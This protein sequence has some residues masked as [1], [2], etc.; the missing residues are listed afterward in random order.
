[1]WRLANKNLSTPA[2]VLKGLLWHGKSRKKAE[3][4]FVTKKRLEAKR[5]KGFRDVSFSTIVSTV[6]FAS[7]AELFRLGNVVISRKLGWSMGG[8]MSEPATFR[9]KR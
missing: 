1:M 6:E 8:P 9:R 3:G 7:K 4:H 2:S 5:A